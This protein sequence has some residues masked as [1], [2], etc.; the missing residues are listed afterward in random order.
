MSKIDML[1]EEIEN[2][3]VKLGEIEIKKNEWYFLERFLKNYNI[4]DIES[5]SQVSGATYLMSILIA[6]NINMSFEEL[7]SKAEIIKE[8]AD[9]VDFDNERYKTYI[10]SL[11]R[12]YDLGIIDKIKNISEIKKFNSEEAKAF[13]DYKKLSNGLFTYDNDDDEFVYHSKIND[14]F[15]EL[16]KVFPVPN[17]YEVVTDLKF[18][19]DFAMPA[20]FSG[21]NDIKSAVSEDEYTPLNKKTFDRVTDKAI[22]KATLELLGNFFDSATGQR[23][24]QDY[25]YLVDSSKSLQSQVKSEVQN[26]NKK[27]KKLDTFRHKLQSINEKKIIK[28]DDYKEFLFDPNIKKLFVQFCIE[29]NLN[30]YKEV[31]EKNKEYKNNNINKLEV[32]FTKYGFNF[33]DLFIEEQEAVIKASETKNMEDALALIKY[34]DLVFLTEY[35]K[36]FTKLLLDVDI[37]VIKAIDGAIK[38]KIID[39][40]FIVNNLDVLYDENKYRNL[41]KNI[42]LLT[43]NG[44]NLINITKKNPLILIMDNSILKLILDILDEYNFSINENNNLDILTDNNLLDIVDNFVELGLFSILKE[45]QRYLNKNSYNII[46]RILISNLVGI[47]YINSNNKLVGQI[48]S[49]N[50]FYISPE[51]YDNYIVN[52]EVCYLNPSCVEQL[53]NDKRLIISDD[54]KNSDA[55]SKLDELYQRS[56]LVYEINGVTI[57]RNRVLRNF[58]LLKER[59]DLDIT[60]ALYQA[61]IYKIIH[62]IT[63]EKLVE[64]Y[65]SLKILDLQNEKIYRK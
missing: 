56:K 3:I 16:F 60:D 51:K 22:K 32:L 59:D 6:D 5:Y 23:I 37:K 15:V 28:I 53:E 2:N 12:M 58:E 20:I 47:N 55:I 18:A 13:D 45:N 57:S 40:N 54:V 30:I 61:I 46:K 14:A 34:S 9:E 65:N 63:D 44:I 29:H 21:I 24:V 64:I 27:L 33:N 26:I 38:N 8:F 1:F 17:R 43:I 10:S 36:E 41:S 25:K 19:T 42:N 49:G 31:E 11:K 39:K 7:Y 4:Y 48:T 35:H 50:K 52:E 62:N